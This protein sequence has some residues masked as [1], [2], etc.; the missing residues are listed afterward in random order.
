MSYL[1]RLTEDMKTAMKAGDK[2]RLS[3]IRLL[4]GQLKDV[5]IEKR[6]D[7][8]DEEE[9]SVLSNALKKR[10]ESIDAYQNAGRMD[11]VQKEQKEL[12]VIQSYLPAQLSP[13]EIEAVVQKV[14]QETG[15][16]TMKDLGKVMP[17]VMAAVKGRADG[18]LVNE[19]VRKKLA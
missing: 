6:A 5:M 13:E 18:R 15:A 4:R 10:R 9:I 3:V 19:L 16:Q 1:A 2:D 17:A 8:T 14:I 11:L 12:E 7:L